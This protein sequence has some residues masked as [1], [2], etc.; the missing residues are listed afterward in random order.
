MKT[1]TLYRL[2][3]IIRSPL[4]LVPGRYGRSARLSID[5]VADFFIFRNLQHAAQS[6]SLIRWRDRRFLHDADPEKHFDAHYIYHTA[7][8]ARLLAADPP[9]MHYDFSSSLYFSAI[10]SAF[11]PIVFLDYRPAKLNLAGFT[12]KHC[13][14]VNLEMEDRSLES[15]SCMHVIEHIGLGRYGDPLDPDGDKNACLELQRVSRP[16][17]RLIIV[18]PVGK[19]RIEFNAHRVYAYRDVVNLF[20]NCRL[21]S[22]ALVPDDFRRGLLTNPDPQ[23]FDGQTYGCGCFEFIKE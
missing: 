23:E 13:D 19:P 22:S 9:S 4:R 14:L 16:G 6:H 15:V 20:A 8:A 5:Q 11:I 7:W 2:R 1:K 17:A 18:V 10:A 3:N 21:E 12:G